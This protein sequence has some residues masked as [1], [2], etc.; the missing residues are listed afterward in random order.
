MRYI[1]T[2]PSLYQAEF[3]FGMGDISI[4]KQVT[5]A[6]LEEESV[7]VDDQKICHEIRQRQWGIWGTQPCKNKLNFVSLGRAILKIG[8]WATEEELTDVH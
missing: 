4:G 7:E 1:L 8:G 2:S 6:S 3:S 5:F